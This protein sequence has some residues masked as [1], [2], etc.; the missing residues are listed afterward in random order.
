MGLFDFLRDGI[1]PGAASKTIDGQ[2]PNPIYRAR[3][4]GE[5]QMDEL[6]GICRG[7]LVDGAVSGMEANYLL[8]WLEANR[9]T[10]HV[11]PASALYERLLRALEDNELDSD[12][13]RDLITIMQKLIGADTDADGDGQQAVPINRSTS[14]PLDQPAP[15]IIFEGKTFCFT[16]QF[17]CGS[18]Q[19]CEQQ[20]SARGGGSKPNISKKVN[21]LVIGE[22][23]SAEWMHSTHGRKIEAAM[24]LKEQ[25]HAIHVIAEQHWHGALK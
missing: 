12:E 24:A 16:G 3:A 4:V 15:A 23:G 17:A 9:N 7:V 13:Q 25:G 6:I 11:W 20:I 5:R 18:R 1:A 22:I 10:A 21:Y 8:R 14:L 2:A 19:W